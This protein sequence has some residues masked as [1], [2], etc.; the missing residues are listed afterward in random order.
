VIPWIS[1][2]FF[3][4]AK[5]ADYPTRRLPLTRS[6]AAL[7]AL[8][9]VLA[10]W[11]LWRLIGNPPGHSGDHRPSRRS[12]GAKSAARKT[13]KKSRPGPPRANSPP[14]VLARRTLLQR[15]ARI[16]IHPKFI[17][18]LCQVNV[19][20][21][22][23]AQSR[24]GLPYPLPQTRPAPPA[25]SWP[26]SPPSFASFHPFSRARYLELCMQ[27]FCLQPGCLSSFFGLLNCAN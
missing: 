12:R 14:Q 16:M 2:R 9:L 21:S 5:A 1:V 13:S 8:P 15:R 11:L 22:T 6:D 20:S 4:F 23:L 26:Y 24:T 19:A 10:S 3:L 25:Q 27:S 18:P 17:H 7:D